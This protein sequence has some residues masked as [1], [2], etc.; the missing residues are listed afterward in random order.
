MKQVEKDT[1]HL[2]NDSGS[3]VYTFLCS[4]TYES[5][6]NYYTLLSNNICK[7]DITPAECIWPST[8]LM[9]SIRQYLA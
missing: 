1:R 3:I 2:D 5:Y 9:W 6:I 8:Q 7:G 4:L